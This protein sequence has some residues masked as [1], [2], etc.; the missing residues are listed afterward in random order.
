MR[1]IVVAVFL[2]VSLFLGSEAAEGGEN[3]L[4]KE[5]PGLVFKTNYSVYSGYLYANTAKTWKLHYMLTESKHDPKND[6]L[7]F[8]FNG[9][10][11][12]SSFSGAFEELG[13]FYVSS[14]GTTLFEN[15]FSW[16]AHANVLYLES[17]IG[18]GFSYD[19]TNLSYSVANDAQSLE[20][21][22]NGIVDFFNRSQTKYKDRDFYLS[23]ES[24]A[25]V[26]LP[27][28]AAKIAQNLNK[29]FP[30]KNFKGVAIGNGFMN[31]NMLSNSLVRWSF[32]HGRIDEDDWETLKS[33]KC[34]VKSTFPPV[35][36]ESGA[37]SCDW[38]SH[39]QSDNGIDFRGNS[40]ECGQ[41]LNPIINASGIYTTLDPYNYYEDCYAGAQ[42]TYKQQR[43]RRRQRRAASDSVVDHN[44]GDLINRNS[45]D[46]L[47]GYPCWQENYVGKYMNNVT[48]Q[49]AFHIDPIWRTKNTFSDC[50]MALYN[51]YKITVKDTTSYF[52]TILAN[53][54]VI[55]YLTLRQNQMSG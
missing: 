36:S 17:P 40:D 19:T 48:V 18:T 27:M 21:H 10:P 20:Q 11:G 24:Y 3:D 32:Y 47:W 46:P 34:C 43:P 12:C 22:Y 30:N 31:V 35:K 41:I 44:M 53:V 14:D 45:T 29:G 50:N 33:S 2:T 8:W 23:G 16:N 28:L 15:V 37:E 25:G 42:I 49:D 38:T 54:S 13:P 51:Q 9:G 6:P 4:V 39:L 5:V 52:N 26:Y 1:S 7:L 55:F